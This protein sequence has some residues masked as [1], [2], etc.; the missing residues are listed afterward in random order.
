MYL[1]LL[2]NFD[3]YCGGDFEFCSSKDELLDFISFEKSRIL[4][5][6]N[7]SNKRDIKHGYKSGQKSYDKEKR[8]CCG[9]RIA[10]RRQCPGR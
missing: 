2:T 9:D 3:P 8:A 5:I 10:G 7:I 1:V 6:Y 4:H